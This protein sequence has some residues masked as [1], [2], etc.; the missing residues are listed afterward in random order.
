MEIDH[1]DRIR[2]NN[3][4]ENLRECSSAQNNHN[5][6]AY[7][8]NKGGCVGVNWSEKN[9]R[10]NAT[11]GNNGKNIYLGSSKSFFEACCFRKSGENT[12]SHWR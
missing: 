12:Y 2:D 10:W 5:V 6:T 11:I 7:G 3:R 9:K 8:K 4:I 1:I